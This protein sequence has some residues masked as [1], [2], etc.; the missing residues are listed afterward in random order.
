M[1][2][3]PERRMKSTNVYLERLVIKDR[4]ELSDVRRTKTGIHDLALPPV[5][6]T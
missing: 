5:I 3:I 2:G 6:F 4:Y 1:L